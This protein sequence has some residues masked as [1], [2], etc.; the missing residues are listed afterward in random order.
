[1]RILLTGARGL[2]ALAAA[3]QLH[4][5]GH[6]V[7]ACD[8]FPRH[9]TGRSAAVRGSFVLPSP[10]FEEE[11]FVRD[12]LARVRAHG[13]DVVLPTGEEA[14][15][16]ARHRARLRCELIAD[17]V[18][19]LAALH[20]KWTFN[21]RVAARGLPAP[22]TWRLQS[23][24][25]LEALRREHP[26]LV[27]KPAFTRFGRQTRV[28]AGHA[29]PNTGFDT[30]F[31]PGLDWARTLLAQE[32]IRGTELC[33]SS[34]L[35]H[36]ALVAHVCY[37][38]R[39]RLPMGPG[40]YF[41]PLAHPGVAAWVQRFM[42]G[43]GFTGSL[44]FDFIETAAG[45]LFALECNPR[46]TSGLL[47]FPDDGRLGRAL[48]GQGTAEPDLDTPAMVGLAM[49]ASALPRLRSHAEV[50]AWWRAVRAARDAFWRPGDTGPFW[51]QLASIPHLW[52]IA[53]QHRITLR[54]A[55]THHTEWNG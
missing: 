13:I 41:E 37:R 49:L 4:R 46:M 10:R 27:V 17:R 6:E 45:E 16:L 50:R 33:A 14:L 48:L 11:A 9:A 22:R 21:Q 35:H 24:A 30:G 29:G 2:P 54:A 28:V 23:A 5:A 32:L 42:A 19:Q 53:R 47:L 43:T 20:D 39:S 38:P 26:R 36:G 31:E 15:Y 52:R 25:H 7:F 12:L 1:M 51:S 44:G 34:V 3:R 18:E 8:T 55:T 40:Y